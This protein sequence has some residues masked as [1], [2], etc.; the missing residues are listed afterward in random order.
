MA[1]APIIRDM[2]WRALLVVLVATVACGFVLALAYAGAVNRSSDVQRELGLLERLVLANR[3]VEVLE[4]SPSAGWIR[5]Q[6]APSR[7]ELLFSF[8]DLT[9]GRT[10]VGLEDFPVASEVGWRAAPWVPVYSGAQVEG[11]R[12]QQT[13]GVEAGE[14]RLLTATPLPALADYYTGALRREGMWVEARMLP[15]GAWSAQA[16]TRDRLAQVAVRLLPRPRGT[17]ILIEY[18]GR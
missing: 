14:L 13:D 2:R 15:S 18:A 16:R 5:A 10:A 11:H 6:H 12:Y 1:H 4:L 7:R 3:Y 9:L 17:Q 8:R